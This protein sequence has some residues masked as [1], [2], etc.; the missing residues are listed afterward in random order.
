[1]KS[2]Q[3]SH[4]NFQ[5]STKQKYHKPS[6]R[7]SKKPFTLNLHAI[8]KTNFIPLTGSNSFAYYDL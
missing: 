6:T 2:H 5:M 4:Y 1:M 8:S 7:R 3:E